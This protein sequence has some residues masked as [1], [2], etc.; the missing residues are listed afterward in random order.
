ME[1]TSLQHQSNKHPQCCATHHYYE[2]SSVYQCRW[3]ICAVVLHILCEDPCETALSCHKATAVHMT[4]SWLRMLVWNCRSILS[5][6]GSHRVLQLLLL[7]AGSSQTSPQH[8]PMHQQQQQQRDA[9]IQQQNGG[10]PEYCRLRTDRDFYRGHLPAYSMAQVAS[11]H[12]TPEYQWT[13]S[14]SFY[15]SSIRVN[16]ST[17]HACCMISLKDALPLPSAEQYSGFVNLYGPRRLPPPFQLLP[18]AKSGV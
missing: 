3:V 2:K 16:W 1:A 14:S 17:Q 5:S 13:P 15:I 12:L 7:Q 10:E 9:R 8:T 11:R 18:G 6:W 4:T